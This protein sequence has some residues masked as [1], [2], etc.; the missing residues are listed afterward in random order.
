MTGRFGRF[1][2]GFLVPGVTDGGRTR[3]E[4]LL[5]AGVLFMPELVAVVTR[6]LSN[7]DPTRLEA[8]RDT[9]GRAETGRVDVGRA[10]TGRVDPG[11]ADAGREDPGRSDG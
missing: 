1:E 7:R 10:E 11:R 3:A 2:I 6:L 5:A 9:F 8:G 4:V